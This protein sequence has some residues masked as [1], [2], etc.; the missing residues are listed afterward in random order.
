M[1]LAGSYRETLEQ[2]RIDFRPATVVFHPAGVA[3]DADVVRSG[4]ELLQVLAAPAL[5]S[6]AGPARVSFPGTVDLTRTE[7]GRGLRSIHELVPYGA[8]HPLAIEEPVAE[9]IGM[10]TRGRRGALI[11][12]PHR[13]EQ[14]TSRIRTDFATPLTLSTL[15]ACANV[16]PVHLPHTYRRVYGISMRDQIGRMRVLTACRLVR[17]ERQPVAEAALEAGF[18]DETQFIAECRRLAV[19]LPFNQ[20]EI[21]E[22]LRQYQT[23][24]STRLLGGEFGSR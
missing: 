12:A 8:N 18:A 10:L 17:V 7:H 6:S 13:M 23:T 22:I 15:A 20:A 11:D 4:T 5:T 1:L 3:I 19:R 2:E 24:R 9:L 21:A 16:S 14:V